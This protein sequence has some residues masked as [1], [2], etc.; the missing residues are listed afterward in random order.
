MSARLTASAANLGH[1]FAYAFEAEAN[2]D[3]RLLHGE[4]VAAG[5]GVASRCQ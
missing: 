1:T 3:G 4:A 2:Y 5:M